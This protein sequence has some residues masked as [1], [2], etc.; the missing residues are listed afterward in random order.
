MRTLRDKCYEMRR[1]RDKNF[2]VGVKQNITLK[3]WS[4][5]LICLKTEI[6]GISNKKL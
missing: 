6:L 3:F 1:L 4:G 2:D 5:D